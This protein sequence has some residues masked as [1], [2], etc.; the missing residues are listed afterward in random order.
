M[1]MTEGESEDAGH[2][3]EHAVAL[4]RLTYARSSEPEA[5]VLALC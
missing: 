5:G 1:G 4:S 2:S 3:G